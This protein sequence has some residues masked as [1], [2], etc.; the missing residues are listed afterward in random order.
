MRLPSLTLT[1]KGAAG[2]D[3]A[4]PGP[5]AAAG[6]A[7][8]EA[9]AAAGPSDSK[10]CLVFDC[11]SGPAAPLRASWSE[12]YA[13]TKRDPLN[14]ELAPWVRDVLRGVL[15]KA[16]GQAAAARPGDQGT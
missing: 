13:R 14:F 1:P 16:S 6:P 2:G 10:P 15:P 7:G 9:E 12:H 11:A 8:G 4:P 3:P 5:R